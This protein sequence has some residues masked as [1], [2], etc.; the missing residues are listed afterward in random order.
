VD[1][2]LFFHVTVTAQPHTFK[3]FHPKLAFK[4]P[5]QALRGERFERQNK[6]G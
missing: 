2:L 6:E 3:R 1:R 4:K 5:I